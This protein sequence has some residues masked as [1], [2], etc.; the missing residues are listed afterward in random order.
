MSF[1]HS[2]LRIGHDFMLISL[3]LLFW[4]G[5]EHPLPSYETPP[6]GP[7]N[8]DVESPPPSRI[9]FPGSTPCILIDTA[10][11]CKHPCEYIYRSIPYEAMAMF[12][13]ITYLEDHGPTHLSSL[14]LLIV[15]VRSW[16]YWCL[17]IPVG[18]I[19]SWWVVYEHDNFVTRVL[20]CA[21]DIS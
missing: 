3:K 15:T 12:S 10:L 6:F 7:A 11:L 8:L 19:A 1:T 13:A 9:K 16:L 14:E 5:E 2:P 20:T 17:C 21:G 18:S 4:G